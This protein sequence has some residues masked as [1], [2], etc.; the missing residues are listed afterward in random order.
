MLVEADPPLT[1]CCSCCKCQFGSAGGWRPDGSSRTLLKSVI[2]QC[3]RRKG[4]FARSRVGGSVYIL[5]LKINVV[6]I[7][8]FLLLSV[9]FAQALDMLIHNKS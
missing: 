8:L 1:D 2:L 6:E 7:C 4:G 3:P 9:Q 5:V